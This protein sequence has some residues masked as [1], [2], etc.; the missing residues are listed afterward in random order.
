MLRDGVEDYEYFAVLRRLLAARG[1]G[2]DPA[3]RARCESLLQVPAAVAADL[4]H[5]TRDP[6]PLEVHR[7]ALAR[8]IE[9]LSRP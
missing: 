8:A 1:T 3:L 4:T 2:L 5:F 7:Q 6:A 9:E